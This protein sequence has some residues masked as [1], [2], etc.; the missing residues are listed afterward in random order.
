MNICHI[1]FP[2]MDLTSCT[3]FMFSIHTPPPVLAL[4]GWFEAYLSYILWLY[5]LLV[6]V[7]QL[8]CL[9]FR[10]KSI[11]CH[12]F[13]TF[14]ECAKIQHWD[15]LLGPGTMQPSA[16]LINAFSSSASAH[17][18]ISRASCDIYQFIVLSVHPSMVAS[19]VFEEL[20]VTKLCCVF[21]LLR[22]LHFYEVF[23]SISFRS[24][25]SS[26]T[27]CHVTSLHSIQAMK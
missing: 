4:V 12:L 15:V 27:R 24:H 18:R 20:G 11:H 1:L 17:P 25:L 5:S 6:K 14:R 26:F 19:I 13:P 8:V 21:F 7:H 10:M 22:L 3:V 23:L 16:D 9:C 2:L